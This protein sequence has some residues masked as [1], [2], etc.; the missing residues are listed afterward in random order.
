MKFVLLAAII[1]LVG[2]GCQWR[3]LTDQQRVDS[4][5]LLKVLPSAPVP[6]DFDEMAR[7]T[8]EQIRLIK[9]LVIPVL[10]LGAEVF[11]FPERQFHKTDPDKC[12]T[13][14]YHGSSGLTLEAKVVAEPSNA[15][16]FGG[17]VADLQVDPD[18]LIE[19]FKKRSVK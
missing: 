16:G 6:R 2:A 18:V 13:V 3:E 10:T 7:M 5:T 15:C 9:P 17:Q 19:W 4:R 12:A 1:L 8:P 14:H 11:P